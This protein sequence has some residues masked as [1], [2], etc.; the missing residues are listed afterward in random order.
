MQRYTKS[1]IRKDHTTNLQK[2]R[3][4]DRKVTQS[5]ATELRILFPGISAQIH[6][7]MNFCHIII[8]QVLPTVLSTR[9]LATPRDEL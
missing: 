6:C 4:L 2:D 8:A 9:G 3:A 5:I 7:V 1:E